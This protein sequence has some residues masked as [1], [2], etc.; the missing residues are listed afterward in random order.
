LSGWLHSYRSRLSAGR[1]YSLPSY[2]L[3]ATLW[4]R[5][6]RAGA[7]AWLRGWPR[8]RVEGGGEIVVGDDVGLYP[9]VRLAASQGAQL[10]IGDG[11]Y[12]N[13]NTLVHARERV[14]IGAGAMVAWD[15]VITDTQ[16]HGDGPHV[17][18]T[19][20][21]TIGDRAWIGAKA[22]VLGGAH[23]GDGAVV[24]AGAVVSGDVPAGAIIA[25]RPGQCIKT[26]RNTSHG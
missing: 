9:G 3:G 26:L 4:H 2:V 16:G 24:A 7:V 5:F 19:A 17:G 23:I 25:A 8:P 13:R 15:V 10:S 1:T 14:T 18:P 22:L 6:T 21:V 12:L 20:P 11:T